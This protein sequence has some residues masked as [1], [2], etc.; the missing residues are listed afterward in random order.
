VLEETAES[1]RLT[2]F[3]T[4]RMGG[5]RV[6]VRTTDAALAS[7]LQRGLNQLVDRLEQSGYAPETL[8]ITTAGAEAGDTDRHPPDEEERHN[9]RHFQDG[10]ET[11][12]RH[13]QNQ[14]ERER[15]A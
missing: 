14:R 13:R 3:M 10:Q 12:Q 2:L 5:V 6:S 8:S 4:E 7:D 1:E 9:R 11:G 15:H